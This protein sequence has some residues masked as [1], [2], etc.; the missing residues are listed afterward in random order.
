MTPTMQLESVNL[1]PLEDRDL[2][3]LQVYRNDPHILNSL[4][5]YSPGM[6]RADLVAWL[7]YH[8]SR[9]DE[10]MWC[11]ANR[12]DDS[13]LGHVGLYQINTRVRKAELGIMIGDADFRGRGVGH[14]VCQA[15]IAHALGELNLRRIE[16][17]F[18]AT[19]E[20]AQKLYTRLGFLQEGIQKEAEYRS[21]AFVDVVLMSLIRD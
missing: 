15:V 8:R 18:L 9:T 4:G 5:G 19:N 13:C 20:A 10:A 3:A 16:L 14:E 7:Q 6:T 11:I 17:S 2:A 12:E 1:R 21:G